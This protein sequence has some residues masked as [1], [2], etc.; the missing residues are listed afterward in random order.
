MAE[1]WSPAL[2]LRPNDLC[3]E[4]VYFRGFERGIWEQ[5]SAAR[6]IGLNGMDFDACIGNPVTELDF[7]IAARAMAK[8][9]MSFEEIEKNI[10]P[11]MA[12]QRRQ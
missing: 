12:P 3:Y 11:S 6:D 4:A 1:G 9:Q 10:F 2:F 8:P 5:F 7:Y